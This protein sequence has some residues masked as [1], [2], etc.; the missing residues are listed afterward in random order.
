VERL[1]R[2]AALGRAGAGGELPDGSVCGL[3]ALRAPGLRRG[4]CKASEGDAALGEGPV[5]G[6][7]GRYSVSPSRRVKEVGGRAAD[8]LGDAHAARK[9]SGVRSSQR[10]KNSACWQLVSPRLPRF[11][12]V[13]GL[14]G[15]LASPP[16]LRAAFSA[17]AMSQIAA[18]APGQ[19]N[20][21]A[22]RLA[23]SAAYNAFPSNSRITGDGS[24]G[25]GSM[26]PIFPQGRPC[27]AS[28]TRIVR[29]GASVS[30]GVERTCVNDGEHRG[31]SRR[32][33][34]SSA[35][36]RSTSRRAFERGTQLGHLR[37]RETGDALGHE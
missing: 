23:S 27:A 13:E 28:P 3:A 12:S 26:W 31:S 34:R 2:R 10:R 37:R 11:C 1:L 33:S 29:R 35:S 32:A 14:M 6:V 5:R 15:W 9:L 17:G 8:P 16:A 24:A 4:G 18:A 36:A 21:S 7:G 19:L 25:P 30:G 22:R 20:P